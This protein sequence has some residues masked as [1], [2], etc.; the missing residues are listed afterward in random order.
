MNKLVFGFKECAHQ[1]GETCGIPTGK[2]IRAYGLDDFLENRAGD[3]DTARIIACK[4]LEY[5]CDDGDPHQERFRFGVLAVGLFL[6]QY[7]SNSPGGGLVD[8]Q[9]TLSDLVAILKVGCSRQQLD[10]WIDSHFSR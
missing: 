10:K 6:D 7:H 2:L 3:D 4:A 1:A 9:Q 8:L 5:F